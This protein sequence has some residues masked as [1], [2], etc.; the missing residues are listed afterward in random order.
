[1]ISQLKMPIFHKHTIH[2]SAHTLL[3]ILFPVEFW[4]WIWIFLVYIIV[5]MSELWMRVFSFLFFFAFEIYG[6][7]SD[8]NTKSSNRPLSVEIQWISRIFLGCFL[9][10]SVRFSLIVNFF[11][12]FSRLFLFAFLSFFLSFIRFFYVVSLCVCVFFFSL[13]RQ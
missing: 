6:R 1:M 7:I 8:S 5:C 13:V 11:L 4:I 2:K 10:C 3:A 9:L 12:F